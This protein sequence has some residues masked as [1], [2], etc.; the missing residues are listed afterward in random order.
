MFTLFSQDYLIKFIHL[1][2]VYI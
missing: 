2:P 1:F